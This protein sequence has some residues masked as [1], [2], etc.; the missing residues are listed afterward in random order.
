M[1]EPSGDTIFSLILSGDIPADIVY[2][3]ELAIAFRDVNPQA[4]VHVLVIPR[5]PIKSLVEITEDDA[6]LIGHL[7]HVCSIVAAA[8]GLGD[9][10]YRVVTNVGRDGGQTVDHIHFHVVGGRPM[11]WPPG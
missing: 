8:E 5:H 6:S 4:P 11:T 1:S 10:G 3:D 7:M 2:E 9:E